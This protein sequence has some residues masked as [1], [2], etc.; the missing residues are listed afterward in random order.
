MQQLVRSISRWPALL[1]AACL[2]I[3]ADL[4]HASAAVTQRKPAAQAHEAKKVVRHAKVVQRRIVHRK[5]AVKPRPQRRPA[6]IRTRVA[7]RAVAAAPRTTIARTSGASAVRVVDRPLASASS[8]AQND[9]PV[10]LR[11]G[12]ALVVDEDTDRVLLSKNADTTRPIAS[13]TKLMTAM[14]LLDAHLP[15]DQVI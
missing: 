1:V 3:G 15:M 10:F 6:A 11:S 5:A 2:L 13:L 4:G 14:V 9:D 7:Y 8:T 12:S